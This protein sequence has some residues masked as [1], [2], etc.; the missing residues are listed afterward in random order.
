[1][2][3]D[4]VMMCMRSRLKGTLKSDYFPIQ[5]PNA[6]TGQGAQFDAV[7]AINASLWRIPEMAPLL[8][9]LELTPVLWA[10]YNLSMGDGLRVLRSYLGGPAW[11]CSVAC[12][13]QPF[14]WETVDLASLGPCTGPRSLESRGAPQPMDVWCERTDGRS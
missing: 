10:N 13:G 11:A 4:N 7:A 9:R 6:P 8:D 12:N 1:M 14:R 5:N 3:L 2:N